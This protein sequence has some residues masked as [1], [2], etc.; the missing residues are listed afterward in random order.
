VMHQLKQAIGV[1][2]KIIIN[3]YTHSWLN[4][5]IGKNPRIIFLRK[6]VRTCNA[7][8]YTSN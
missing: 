7:E 6:N 4:H 5:A 1:T 3:N 2:A 8:R